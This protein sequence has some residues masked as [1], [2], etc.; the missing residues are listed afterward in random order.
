[1]AFVKGGERTF[2]LGAL[3][4]LVAFS[5]DVILPALKAATAHYGVPEAQGGLLVS[6]YFLGFALGQFLFGPLA[7]AFG[8]RPVLMG[9][10]LG[11]LLAGSLTLFA[12]T[13]SLLLWARVFQ[14]FFGAAFRV[15]AT[16]AIRDLYRGE[17]MARRLS[18]A[19]FVLLLAP[20][21]APSLGVA[22]LPLGFRAPF[23][24]P[25]LLALLVLLWGA[26]RFGET[27]PEERR[28]PLALGTLWEGLLLVLRD[29]RALLYTL[30][31]G[32]LF[33]VLYAYLSAAPL[34]Y[35]RLGLSG[36]GFALAFGGT[37]LLQAL[38]NLLNGRT[39]EGLGLARSL[40]LSFLALLLALAFLP[41]TALFPSALGLWLH[42]SLVL[43]LVT[44]AF[45]NAQARALEGLGRVAGLA[46][47]FTGFFSTLLAS[48]LA[49]G[50]G[51]ASRGEPV[52]F[53]LGLLLLGLLAF[54]AQRGAEA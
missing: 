31:L 5:I 47:S 50:V 49:T 37:G 25:V 45:P 9:A 4:G 15:V 30:A 8:R 40:R 18:Q 7:D 22:L 38:A 54:L 12:P 16:A 2:Y 6:L 44:L 19:L 3:M 53:A 27:L 13:F 48:L 26:L 10:L 20:V 23:A 14:G 52:P 43:F 17:A 32:A 33:G 11:F 46:A 1:M 24:F 36:L 51:Q 28:R 34:L 41:L 39:V 29:R 35:G 21:L 42:L